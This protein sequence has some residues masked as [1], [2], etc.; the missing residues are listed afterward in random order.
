M[1]PKI[2]YTAQNYQDLVINEVHYNPKDTIIASDTISGKNFGFIELKNTGSSSIDLYNVAFTKGIE[3][4]IDTQIS[5][6]AGGFVVFAEDANWFESRYGFAP[7]GVYEGKLNDEGEKINLKDPHGYFIDSVRYDANNP[8]DEAPDNSDF[9]LELLHG[10]LDNNNPLHWFRS[11]NIHGTPKAENSRTCAQATSTIVINEINYNSNNDVFDPG[12]WVEFYNPNTSAVDI[13]GWT[14]YDDNNQFI[15]PT[16]TTIPANG[17]LVLVE[18]SAVFSSAF[19]DVAPTSYIGNIPFSLSNKGERISL[20]DDNKCLVDYVI[21]DDKA[22]WATAPDGDGATLALIDASLDNALATSWNASSILVPSYTY[23]SPGK[24]NFCSGQCVV[25]AKVLL[26]GYYDT[27]NNN[28]HTKLVDKNLLPLSQPFNEAPWNY[29]G[30][31]SV[32][33]IPSGVVDWILISTRDSNGDILNQAAGFIN[34][35]GELV[36]LDGS[37]GI[38]IPDA[39]G[40]KISIHHHSH[41]AIISSNPFDGDIYD[42]TISANQ[43]EGVE[44][45]KLIDG[46]YMLYAGD[47]D[48][49][50]I[51]NS[52][53]FNDW[54]TQSAALNQYLNI[55]GDGNGIINSLDFNL[56]QNN[57][58]KIGQP[59]IQY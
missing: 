58:S 45:L 46:K 24:L 43:A 14:L 10:D 29:N 40:N 54:K 5:I 53:D 32:T 36:S 4:K 7:D 51:I 21:Y 2:F 41:L 25:N 50:G 22:P 13:S 19:P 15:I 57:K 17:Y 12:D 33:S 16:G 9:T 27:A 52:N 1:C 44:Q 23:G 18:D 48:C 20:F 3:L 56:W 37:N 47:Y 42:F 28:M 55:D 26:E 59:V 34:Q 49:T 31:E 35:N 38:P 8:W 11:D 39:I 6:P 30:T